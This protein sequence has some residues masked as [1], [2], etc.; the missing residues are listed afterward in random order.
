MGSC[1]IIICTRNRAPFLKF[2]LEHFKQI[3]VPVD[4]D[5][6]LL[7]VDNGSTDDTRKVA[8]ECE[9]PGLG[10]R[11]LYEPRK[12]QCFAR[13]SGVDAAKGE[14]IL[15]TD[16]DVIPSRHW[17]A[18]MCGP[19]LSGKA[20]AVAG[21]VI[22]PPHLQRPWMTEMTRS[23]MC[24]TSRLD[25]QTP[26]EFVGANMA[27]ARHV[28]QKVPRFDT[29]LGPGALG[30][31]DDALFAWQIRRAGYHIAGALDVTVEHH[32]DPQR[33]SRKDYLAGAAARGRG[34]GYLRYHWR[35]QMMGR[36]RL[37]LIKRTFRLLYWRLL[38]RPWRQT[39]GAPDWELRLLHDICSLRYFVGE[40]S[41]R[42]P[43]KYSRFGLVKHDD[44][45]PPD[46]QEPAIRDSAAH[47]SPTQESSDR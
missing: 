15:F 34:D 18:G 45:A 44:L 19:I 11:Y 6:E 36:D 21:G 1:S 12:G 39:Q 10:V 8:Q 46:P 43:R 29:D 24:D 14:V 35:H 5:A 42:R 32:F 47:L 4:L 41:Q 25:P 23:M 30:F 26:S 17:L 20:D 7:V 38:R 31:G 37:Y 13:N 22:I 33:L 3:D 16:D 9:I 2:T 40:A 28:L 27:F